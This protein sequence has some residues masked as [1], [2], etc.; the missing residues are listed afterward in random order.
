MLYQVGMP[1]PP[2]PM[3]NPSHL[4]SCPACYA[5]AALVTVLLAAAVLKVRGLRRHRTRPARWY[6]SNVKLPRTR[7]DD[8]T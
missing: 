1:L 8:Y 4:P 7:A 6:R 2:L 3:L 5:A